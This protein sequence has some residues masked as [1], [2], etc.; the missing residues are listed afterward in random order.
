MHGSEDE[1]KWVD[2]WEQLVQNR[3]GS[4]VEDEVDMNVVIF[5]LDFS[6]GNEAKVEGNE[7]GLDKASYL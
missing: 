6:V 3:G 4:A 5:I 1:K 2:Q 7:D